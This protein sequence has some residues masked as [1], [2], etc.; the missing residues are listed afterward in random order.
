MNLS[1]ATV[2]AAA[3]AVMEEPTTKVATAKR[4]EAASCAQIEAFIS[5]RLIQEGGRYPLTILPGW[6]QPVN[7]HSA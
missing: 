3:E 1:T 2:W 4:P 7:P 6:P 5:E